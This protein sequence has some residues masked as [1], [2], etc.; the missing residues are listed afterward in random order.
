VHRDIKPGNILLGLDAVFLADFG[1]VRSSDPGDY[2]LT[3]QGRILGTPS[4]QSPEQWKGEEGLDGRSDI[5]SLG[6]VLFEMLTGEPPFRGPSAQAVGGK[7]LSEDPPPVSM[8]RPSVSREMDR[9]ISRAMAKDPADRFESASEFAD[10]LKA[11]LAGEKTGQGGKRHPS[12]R[13]W[14]KFSALAGSL[15]GLTV[16]IWLYRETL[17]PIVSQPAMPD[18]TRYAVYAQ[19]N[20]DGSSLGLDAAQRLNTALERWEGLTVAEQ[21]RG[22]DV[23][24]SLAT[25]SYPEAGLVAAARAAGA[26]RVVRISVGPVGQGFRVNGELLDVSSDGDLLES[27]SVLIPPD[28]A[29]ADSV[30]ADLADHL[31]FRGFLGSGVPPPTDRQ[32]LTGRHA[33]LRGWNF[34]EAGDLMGADSAFLR[35]VDEDPLVPEA[36]LWIA[37]SRAWRRM[38]P[39]QWKDFAQQAAGN[40][41]L[42]P[43][44]RVMADALLA[45][46]D[47]DFERACAFWEGLTEEDPHAFDAWLGLA[48]CWEGD[49]LVVS[50]P[51]S[52][53]GWA[54]RT[55]SHSTVQAYRR[56]FELFPPVLASYRKGSYSQLR[57]LFWTRTNQR[58]TGRSADPGGPTFLAAPVWR[59]DS[60]SLIPFPQH[61]FRPEPATDSE[62]REVAVHQ[63]RSLFRDLAQGWVSAQPQSPYANEALAIALSLLG[64]PGALDRI[65]GARVL[66]RTEGEDLRLSGVEAWIRLAFA[67][68]DNPSEI[69]KA[70]SLVDSVLSG[71]AGSTEKIDGLFL[72]SLA[73]LTGKAHRAANLAEGVADQLGAPPPLKMTAPALLIYA[74]LGGPSDTLAVLE[75]RVRTIIEED[76]IPEDRL[77]ARQRWL[78]RPATLAFYE[79]RMDAVESLSGGV[80]FFLDF[81]AALAAHDSAAVRRG[82]DLLRQAREGLL[83][84]SVTLD[85]LLPETELLT[86]LGESR[87]AAEW[88]DRALRALP[89]NAPWIMND[90]VRAAALGRI[91]VL[92]ATIAYELEDLE[93]AGAWLQAARILWSDADPFLQTRL[94]ELD[95]RFR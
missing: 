34:L 17:G 77:G 95:R 42:P 60:L 48:T 13:H 3:Q 86:L 59:G 14:G 15:V 87:E 28:L 7:H 47:E 44:D 69:E 62:G 9:V 2:D 20:E 18:T 16:I 68:P 82:F 22:S 37:L 92:R 23:E 56:A 90:P 50:D 93:G 6:C 27:Y 8:L 54:F 24:A 43:R 10:S 58:R 33:F 67:L 30:F 5:Y 88:L 38:E 40:R 32:S 94:R 89:Q 45:Q 75:T 71:D 57:H 53:S 85:A 74:A 64:D 66:A 4:Y 61:S 26:G 51:G 79:H 63:Q 11:A 12:R 31:I 73:A 81:Q 52:P 65:V 76:V 25:A 72:A 36:H 70:R 49:A 55:S 1:I 46:A 80:D 78:A 84:G 39:P 41:S 83:P 35:A 29:G 91:L 21:L 19:P